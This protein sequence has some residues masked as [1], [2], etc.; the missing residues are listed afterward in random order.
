ML[1]VLALVSAATVVAALWVRRGKVSM[2]RILCNIA[3]VVGTLSTAQMIALALEGKPG[4]AS[5]LL[6]S[7]VTVLGGCL[8]PFTLL[9]ALVSPSL[10][11]MMLHRKHKVVLRR[12]ALLLGL[13]CIMITGFATAALV[14]QYNGDYRMFNVVVSSQM[15]VAAAYTLA[16]LFAI[17]Y[18]SGLLFTRMDALIS[19]VKDSRPSSKRG[20]LA[21]DSGNINVSKIESHRKKLGK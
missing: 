3:I 6:C 14:Y 4:I 8:G 21:G 15:A 5:V 10:D 20:I 16:W 13:F 12:M 9:W 11:L 2:P 18:Y 19:S 7:A 17:K 1:T